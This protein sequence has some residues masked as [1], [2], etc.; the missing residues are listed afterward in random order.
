MPYRQILKTVDLILPDEVAVLR[1][2]IVPLILKPGAV[3]KTRY[4]AYSNGFDW[5]IQPCLLREK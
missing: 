3:S 1:G 4:P 5:V 2:K